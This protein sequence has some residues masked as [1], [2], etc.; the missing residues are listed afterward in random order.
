MWVLLWGGI[1]L[2]AMFFP[3]DAKKSFKI[4]AIS[5]GVCLHSPD[6]GWVKLGR[7]EV[8]LVLLG[9]RVLMSFHVFA[10]PFL[11]IKNWG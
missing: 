8:A 6:K 3:T 11:P 10:L 4:F 5:A 7:V 9:N 1:I 2:L